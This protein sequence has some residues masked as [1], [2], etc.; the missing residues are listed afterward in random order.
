MPFRW[1]VLAALAMRVA[2]AD[3][4]PAKPKLIVMEPQGDGISESALRALDD[5]VLTEISKQNRYEVIGS[6]DVKRMLGA[7]EL[8]QQAGCDAGADSCL[9]E[10]GGALGAQFLCFTSL[11]KLGTQYLVNVKLIDV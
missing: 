5:M 3:P 1:F 2:A 7:V 4:A 11:A 9:T 10:I 8:R 6:S